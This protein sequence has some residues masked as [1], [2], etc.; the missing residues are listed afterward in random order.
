MN[1]TQK[2]KLILEFLKEKSELKQ[3]VYDATVEI[4]DTLKK[5]LK[6]ISREY[7]QQLKGTVKPGVYL[8]YRERGP[9]EVELKIAGD[10][11]IFSLHS[12]IFEFDREHPVWKTKYIQENED[13]TFS[14]MICVYNFLADSF[15]YNRL[16]DLGYLIGRIF[17][18]REKHFMI[19]GKRQKESDNFAGFS[20]VKLGKTQLRQ[21][22]ENAIV[23]TLQFDLLA[24][25]YDDVKI[26]SV[27]QMQEKISHSKIQTGKRVG[28][29]FNADDV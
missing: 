20:T 21:I 26:A 28:F 19:E 24:P 14:G 27:D 2:R 12:N 18:N 5:L 4:F 1:E 17:I 9:F 29:K 11:L 16:Q 25:P 3:Q 22:L 23:Y 13:N 7:N 10:L 8:Q 15:K 6:E